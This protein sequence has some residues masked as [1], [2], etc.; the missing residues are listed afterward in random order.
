MPEERTRTADASAQA[1]STLPRVWMTTIPEL[2]APRRFVAIS[3]VI[4]PLLLLQARNSR[5]PRALPLAALLCTAFVL[6]AP[7]LWRY[8]VP[9]HGA[10]SSAGVGVAKYAAAGLLAVYGIGDL[11]PNALR[12]APTFLTTGQSLVAALVLFW[13]GGWGLARDIDLERDSRE[14]RARAAA[15]E[16][17][18]EHAQLLALRSHLDPHFLFNTLNAI[19]EWCRQDGVVAEKAILRLSSIL[20]TVMTGIRAA[21]W[22]IAKELELVDAL[23][24]MHLIR[25]PELFTYERQVAADTPDVAVP[26]ML[27]LPIAENAMKHGPGAGHRGAVAL[28]VRFDEDTLSIEIE[29]PG[30]YRGRRPGGSGLAIVEKRLDVAYG[31]RGTFAIR[32]EEGRTI[33]AVRV[34]RTFDGAAR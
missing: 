8:F 20:R 12:M 17:E 32:S 21:Q 19:A 10:R 29:N 4:V 33:A 1:S 14:T 27:L 3:V 26:P 9:L 11:L 15:L 7:A 5:D 6:V 34:P 23:F 28:R 24:E 2:F 22:P 31:A 30:A 16:R 13:V 18:A 25:D